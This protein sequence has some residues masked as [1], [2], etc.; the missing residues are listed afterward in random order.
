[1]KTRK[2]SRAVI[3][4][5]KSRHLNFIQGGDW[6]FIASS[7]CKKRYYITVFYSSDQLATEKFEKSIVNIV[8]KI[9]ASNGKFTNYSVLVTQAEWNWKS[10]FRKLPKRFRCAMGLHLLIV[11]PNGIHEIKP[12]MGICNPD[13]NLFLLI[14]SLLANVSSEFDYAK[15]TF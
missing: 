5:L 9:P 3:R 8:T 4:W 14:I 2:V 15:L 7:S 6:D 10:K 11:F 1:M 12:K 13:L